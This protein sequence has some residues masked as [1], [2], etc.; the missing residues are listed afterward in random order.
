MLFTGYENTVLELKGGHFRYWFASDVRFGDEPQYP[1]SGDYEIAGDS[2]TLK[3]PKIHDV[4]WTFRTLDGVPTLWRVAA[5]A[6][7]DEKKVL[8]RYGILC[9]TDKPAED[10][11][12]H[13][14]R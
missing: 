4:R 13:C 8:D 14:G 12:V 9:L 2:I 3:H 10:A 1:L 7:Y 6:L 5:L 11:W